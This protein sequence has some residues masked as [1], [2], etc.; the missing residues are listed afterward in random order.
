VLRT[1]VL[2]A[3]L[4]LIAVPTAQA[5]ELYI[6][7]YNVEN[8]FDTVDDPDVEDDEEFTP[9]GD[10]A[11]NAERLTKKIDNLS[12]VIK[13]MN[14]DK[15]PDVLGVC[16]VENLDCLKLLAK[17][18]V[19]PGRKYSIVHMDS[20]SARGIDCA[21]IFD[22]ERLRLVSSAFH[23]VPDPAAA[24]AFAPLIT[25]FIVEAHFDVG[26]K[27]LTLFMNHWPSQR[28]PAAD[29]A[30]A[31]KVV[32][33]RLDQLLAADALADVV[34]MGDLNDKPGD[35]SVKDELKSTGDLTAAT[36]GRFFNT[37]AAI[38]AMPDRGTYVFDNMWETI[39]HIIVSPGLLDAAGFKWKSGSTT[40]V[41]F[42]EQIF[43]PKN[44][45]QIPRPN[46][47]YTGNSYHESGI[48]DHLPVACVLEF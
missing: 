25:R 9:A 37:M 44:P 24:P 31:A 38:A 40:E 35:A 42:P 28:N 46:R 18:M 47:T 23:T 41:K 12:A 14:S 27:R 20:P 22:A 17:A 4:F 11:W 30:A 1:I 45:K 36:D 10:K 26:G 8:L 29:R 32:R 43:T 15:G 34:V 2:T 21:I 5:D 33:A 48:S 39:D 13:K 3:A 6:A 16:E 19:T 7:S